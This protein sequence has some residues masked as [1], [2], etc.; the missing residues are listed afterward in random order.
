MMML[1]GMI[2]FHSAT[3]TVVTK[4]L[5]NFNLIK[6]AF[7]LWILCLNIYYIECNTSWKRMQIGPIVLLSFLF[8]TFIIIKIKG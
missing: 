1:A 2:Y 8:I 3:C 6:F 4:I 7:L 5:E